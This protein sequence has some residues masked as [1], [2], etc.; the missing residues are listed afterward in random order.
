MVLMVLNCYV[1]RYGSIWTKFQLK[2]PILDQNR[3]KI[4]KLAYWGGGPLVESLRCR[5]ELHPEIQ[6]DGYK[7]RFLA[8]VCFLPPITIAPPFL[9]ASKDYLE[10]Q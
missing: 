3:K 1:N 5:Q 10:S 7:N 4:S 2:Q 6:G 8:D 9:T